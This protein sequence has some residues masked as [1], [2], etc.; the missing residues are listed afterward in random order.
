M[1]SHL[2][3]FSANSNSNLFDRNLSIRWNSTMRA[4]YVQTISSFVARFRSIFV[5]RFEQRNQN[6]LFLL[7][8]HFY[9]RF[10]FL[11]AISSL[12]N[13]VTNKDFISFGQRD[14]SQF[15]RFS[16]DFNNTSFRSKQ[17]LAFTA[18]QSFVWQ[19]LVC[20][21]KLK[22]DRNKPTDG[23]CHK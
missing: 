9:K 19:I 15:Q 22:T 13:C 12:A 17:S 6:L 11:I 3:L 4:N 23:I 2:E 16:Q 1:M 8:R 10:F 7:F 21:L 18:G 14:F 5:L 20:Y